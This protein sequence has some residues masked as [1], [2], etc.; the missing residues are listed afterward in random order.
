[1]FVLQKVDENVDVVLLGNKCDKEAERTIPKQKGEKVGIHHKYMISS[2]NLRIFG[3]NYV[4]KDWYDGE[5]QLFG[6]HLP[7]KNGMFQCVF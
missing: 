2:L 6:H 5:V 4:N 3:C 7:Q 1:M